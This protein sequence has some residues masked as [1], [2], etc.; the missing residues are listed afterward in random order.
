MSYKTILVQVDDSRH[1]ETRIEA[2]AQVAITESAHLVG[3]AATGVA[4]AILYAPISPAD[5]GTMEPYLETLRQRAAAALQN[6]ENIARR[7][8]V[9]SYEAQLVENE[10]AAG[11]SLR[12]RCT[13]LVVL[14]QPDPDESGGATGAD[15]PEYVAM[16]C[17]G[18]SLMIPYATRRAKIGER[19]LVAWNA[20]VEAARA[21][22]FAIPLLKRAKVVEIAIFNPESASEDVYGVPPGV[23][24][25]GF[26]GRHDIKAD[27]IAKTTDE[28]VGKALLSL[29]ENSGCDLLVMGCY[30]HARFRE[31]LL[32]GATRSVLKST[33]VP[34]LMA[35]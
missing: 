5:P 26:L 33:I 17:G 25:Q 20:S 14:G 35:H 2:A 1:A 34:V 6:F 24:I 21:V 4:E 15:F 9:A 13:D 16:N 28:E 19:A 30:G 10:S 8:G 18:P 31:I 3:L 23:N 12:A 27:V 7:V 11:T 22:H 29:A 32:G